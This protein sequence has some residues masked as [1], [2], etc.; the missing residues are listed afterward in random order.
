MKTFELK[1][2]DSLV[3][4]LLKF[5]SGLPEN[6]IKILEKT[7]DESNNILSEE[8]EDYCLNKAMDE[9]KKTPLLNRDEALDYLNRK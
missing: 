9:A 1:I 2:N 5:I 3:D 8:M 4:K 7:S 6:E